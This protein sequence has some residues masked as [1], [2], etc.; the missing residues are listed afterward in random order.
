MKRNTFEFDSTLTFD[1]SR[2]IPN[3]D[4]D[5]TIGEIINDITDTNQGGTGSIPL[6]GIITFSESP[7]ILG[8]GFNNSTTIITEAFEVVDLQLG[9]KRTTAN[10]DELN[11]SSGD[12]YH[13]AGI[14]SKTFNIGDSREDILEMYPSLEGN[15]V[16]TNN[17]ASFSNDSEIQSNFGNGESVIVESDN[18]SI[19]IGD[20]PGIEAFSEFQSSLFEN[21]ELFDLFM[22]IRTPEEGFDLSE[23]PDNLAFLEQ[24]VLPQSQVSIGLGTRDIESAF[25]YLDGAIKQATPVS[26]PGST[27]NDAA[28]TGLYVGLI[29][30]APDTGGLDFWTNGY[31]NRIDKGQS[32]AEALRGVAQNM[33]D[34]GATKEYYPETLSNQEIVDGFYENVLGRQGDA[35]G[36]AFWADALNKPETKTGDVLVDMIDAVKDYSG[37]N[38]EALASQTL[39]EKKLE[40][41]DYYVSEISQPGEADIEVSIRLL[42]AVDQATDTSSDA[43]ISAFVDQVTNEAPAATN[44]TATT[45]AGDAV[46]V[47]VLANDSDADGDALSIHSMGNPTNGAVWITDADTIRYTPDAGFSGI[48][49]FT[50]A[51]S[52]GKGGSDTATIEVTVEPSNQIPGATTAYVGSEHD[53]YPYSAVTYIESEFPNGKTSSGSGAVVGENDVLTASHIIYSPEDGGL[54]DSITV[55]PGLDGYEQPYGS[56]DAAS[57][58]YYE[59]DG[60]GYSSQDE[61]EDEWAVL[62]FDKDFG[63][64]TG[65]FGL[66][67][68]ASSGTY[69]LTGYPG[70]YQTDEGLRMTND[71]GTVTKDNLYFVYNYNSIDSNPGNSGGPLWHQKDDGPYIIGFSATSIWATDITS[72]YSNILDAIDENNY[73]YEEPGALTSAEISDEKGV[74]DD[75]VTSLELAGVTDASQFDV[76]VV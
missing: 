35:E 30:R 53:T 32:E 29:G 55:Y 3:V 14:N 38:Q 7:N 57:F 27:A 10:I 37:D 22:S 74:A 20:T 6:T 76:A 63:N 45:T 47:D 2:T 71:N 4:G 15:I 67:P 12:S 62:G 36:I 69:N 25:F 26:D 75:D 34:A 11:Q 23:Q 64:Q 28:I 66:D 50:Y 16:N 39:F 58:N 72:G 31:R 68:N 52:D 51:V 49:D 65:W 17:A 33:F 9:G 61:S 1:P 24:Q 43:A 44:D 21:F 13:A 70:A 48:D 73:L 5:L 19:S 56:Y 42:N 18:L 41:S 54:A 8:K 60:D 59:V 40:V 46:T